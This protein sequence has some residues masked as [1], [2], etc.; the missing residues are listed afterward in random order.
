M[1]RPKHNTDLH[2]NAPEKAETAL[3][4]VDVLNDFRFRGGAALARQTLDILGTLIR[5]KLAARSHGVPVVYVND[6]SGKWRSDLR[7]VTERSLGRR[8]RGRGIARR[9]LPARADY[10]VLKPKQSAF[11][12]TPLEILL[13]YLGVRRLVIAGLT[14]DRCILFTAQD[15]FVRDYEIWIPSDGVASETPEATRRSLEDMRRLFHAKIC[16]AAGI[17]WK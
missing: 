14:A 4:M 9:M 13:D 3:L 6:N 12:G 10:F 11:Y 1:A 16:P 17:R 8:S 7:R 15:A 2:G 5:L